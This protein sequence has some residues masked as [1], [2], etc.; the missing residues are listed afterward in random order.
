MTIPG[1]LTND[2]QERLDFI[3]AAAQLPMDAQNYQGLA[4]MSATLDGTK[5]VG[6]LI[7]A[8]TDPS[9]PEGVHV[10]PL[11]ILVD[12]ELMDRLDPGDDEF[13]P[14]HQDGGNET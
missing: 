11:A 12:E 13:T 3:V 5:Q 10:H 1:P 4:V 8:A 9:D 14:V 6:V 7:W 2:D